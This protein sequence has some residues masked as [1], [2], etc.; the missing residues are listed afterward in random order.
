M[1][2]STFMAS[3]GR[4]LLIGIIL[5]FLIQYVIYY[6]FT[7]NYNVKVFSAES[8]KKEYN[9]GV[10]RYRLIGKHMQLWVYDRLSSIRKIRDMKENPAYANRLN[11]LDPEVNET[12]YFTYFVTAVI[13]SVLTALCL[14][15]IFDLRPLFQLT[16]S[17]KI[18]ATSFI[19]LFIGF[20]QFAIT[21]YDTL[22]Y[23]LLTLGI[24]TCLKYLHSGSIFFLMA[25]C[26]VIMVATL[27]RESSLM[28]LSFMA[29][30]YWGNNPLFD[31]QWIKKM[32][33][34]AICFLLPYV[35]LRMYLSGNNQFSDGLFLYSNLDVTK[36][37]SMT[38]VF[39][40]LIIL[41]MIFNMA[42]S[43][44]NKRLIRRF[45]LMA[46]PY[47]LIIFLVGIIIEYRLWVPV[48]IPAAILSMIDIPALMRQLQITATAKRMAVNEITVG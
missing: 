27:N 11:Y 19:I 35:A 47:M 43:E 22:S 25:L 39:F 37:S 29:A 16:N 36:L 40:A 31:F 34:P 4:Y 5:P 10:F 28:I 48:I 20:T 18:L 14:L 2:K 23:F 38:G 8:F 30:I 21:P 24:L 42:S 13:F 7:P 33:L 41:Y 32:I 3:L 46:S 26:L 45:M 9:V 6:R 15:L 17:R 12:F 1:I 44:E